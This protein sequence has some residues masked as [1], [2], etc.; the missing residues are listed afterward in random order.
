MSEFKPCPLCGSAEIRTYKDKEG[1]DINS[2]VSCRNC[3]CRVSGWTDEEAENNWNDRAVLAQEAGPVVE[4]QPVAEVQ[5][6][7]FDDVGA[8]Q[9]VRVVTLGDFDLENLPDGTKLFASPPAP[10]AVERDAERFNFLMSA[11]ILNGTLGVSGG[12]ID[13]E[14]KDEAIKQIDA[15]LD[16]VKELNQ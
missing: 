4:R 15:C 12:W 2:F 7:P 13:F 11:E 1:F 9:W 6:G 14:F 16:K 8:P 10:V 3:G 5:H